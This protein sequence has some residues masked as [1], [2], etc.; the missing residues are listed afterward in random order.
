[1]REHARGA[2]SSAG[3]AA[4][5]AGAP[6]GARRRARRPTICHRLARHDLEHAVDH[7]AVAL[8]Q[9]GLD[10][11]VLLAVVVA[12]DHRPHLGDAVRV[13]DVDEVAVRA[14]LHRELRHDD[15]VRAASR[16]CTYAV[17]N[18]PGR[19]SVLRVGQHRA[20]QERAGVL[21]ERR[22]G[23]VDLAAVRIERAVRAAR[24]R[25]RSSRSFGAH[26]LALVDHRLAAAPSGSATR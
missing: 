18:M 12:D 22:V 24:S 25:R 10:H 2:T 7:D 13:D 11:D 3:S 23:E 8:V 1:M 26:D 17:T 6:G 14:L 9:A 20:H 16:P 4:L 19:S 15:R 21:A 5:A